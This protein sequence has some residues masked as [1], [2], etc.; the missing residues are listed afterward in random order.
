[1]TFAASA[2]IAI[3]GRM[4]NSKLIPIVG[5]I[6]IIASVAVCIGTTALQTWQ[7]HDLS[8]LAI[9]ISLRLYH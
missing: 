7:N 9:A 6:G 2:V 1:M 4:D 8:L 5:L 3:I